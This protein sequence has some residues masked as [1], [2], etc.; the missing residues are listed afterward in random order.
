MKYE[1]QKTYRARVVRDSAVLGYSKNKG[2]PQINVDLELID[3]GGIVMTWT[4]YFSDAA[5]P[6][7]I[8]NLRT[9]G[10][11]G[12]DISDLSSLNNEKLVQIVTEPEEFEG[13]VYEKIKFINPV[14]GFTMAEEQRMGDKERKTFAAQMRGA[15]HAPDVAE[16]KMAPAARGTG[17]APKPA[18]RDMGPPSPPL[19]QLEP[20]SDD[21]PL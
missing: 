4:G 3:E 2:T 14:G 20:P 13:K 16:K 11:K 9:L 18:Q 7:T 8:K 1:N 12:D 6:Y 10:F 19:D 17:G 15:F 21:I 5:N